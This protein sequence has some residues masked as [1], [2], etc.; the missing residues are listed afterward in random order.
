MRHV[1]SRGLDSHFY[2]TR[3]PLAL[4]PQSLEL[5]LLLSAPGLLIFDT[6][7]NSE[8]TVSCKQQKCR[9][10]FKAELNE[11]FIISYRN[12]QV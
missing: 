5:T 2:W 1:L 4:P 9:A 10:L 3:G 6:N 12:R 11:L 8:Y 7:L